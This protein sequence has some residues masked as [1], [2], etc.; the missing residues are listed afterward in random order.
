MLWWKGGLL[1]EEE[2]RMS[3]A[4]GYTVQAEAQCYDNYR[5]NEHT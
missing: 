5:A 3:K 4:C 2:S 1:G